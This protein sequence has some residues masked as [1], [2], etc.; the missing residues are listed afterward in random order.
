[1]RILELQK[2]AQEKGYDSLKFKFK[3]L[4]GTESQ[5]QWEDAYFV[6]FKIDGSSGL[7]SVSGWRKEFGDEL[8][9]FEV[10]D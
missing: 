9:E 3:T 8:F 2:L 5:G 10:I 1:M 6:L 4:F 7:L